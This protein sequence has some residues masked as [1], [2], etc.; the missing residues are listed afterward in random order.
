[1]QIP[2]QIGNGVVLIVGINEDV[3]ELCADDVGLNRCASAFKHSQN[4]RRMKR[5]LEIGADVG[6]TLGAMT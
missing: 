5:R 4:P 1:M 3:G 2:V 6:F